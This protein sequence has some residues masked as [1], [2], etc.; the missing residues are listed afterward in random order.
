MFKAAI[1]DLDGTIIDSYDLILEAFAKTLRQTGQEYAPEDIYRLFGPPEEIIFKKLD[2]DNKHNLM[3]I[4]IKCYA[5]CHQDYVQLYPGIKDLL[6]WLQVKNVAR[7]IITGK[8]HA[9]T[10]IT[11]RELGIENCFQT[12]VTGSCV[13]AYK[14]EPDGML[15]VL[16][17]LAV[18]PG[19]AFYLGDSPVDIQVAK[20]TGVVPLAALWGSAD[21]G[22]LLELDPHRA[23]TSPG[24]MLD[25]LQN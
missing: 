10:Q 12:I 23:F 2:P 8:G 20:A 21:P 14:P 4:Y 25:W 6:D 17:E 7:A 22:A 24:E 11:L 18:K 19:E 1:F 9:A 3:N 16:E 5:D 13:N 15:R